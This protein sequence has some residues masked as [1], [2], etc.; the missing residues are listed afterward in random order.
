LSTE[1][2]E[3]W[4]RER[5]DSPE[6]LW[7]IKRL[8]ANDTLASGSHQAGPYLPKSVAFR[9]F[10]SISKPELQNPDAYLT[11]IIDSHG[12][13]GIDVRITWYNAK[14]RDECHI[15]RWG[16]K[17]SP[18][19]DPDATGS[20]AVFAF[21]KVACRDADACRVWICNFEEEEFLQDCL[22]IIDPG[23]PLFLESGLRPAPAR[24]AA[25]PTSCRLT[26]ETMPVSW[27]GQFPAGAEIV[28]HSV[29]LRPL[30]GETAD[31]RLIGRRECEYEMFRSIEEILVLPRIS[32][33][34]SSVDEFIDYSNAVNNRRKSRSGRSLELH[35]ARIFTEEGV[36]HSH[37][38]V[39]EGSKRPD[40]LF[41]SGSHYRDGSGPVWMLAAKTT[42][43]D[44][45]RQIL[46]EADRIPVKHLATLQEGVSSNQYAEM[47]SA[48]VR[49]V[50]PKPL[51][52]RFPKEVRPELLTVEQFISKVRL[53]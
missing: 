15:T 43:K 47:K 4:L 21:Q 39:S 16:G 53:G 27:Q 24:E 5:G 12:L 6:W 2:F 52:T 30:R 23:K 51:H 7:F 38:E 33:G 36:P 22:D 29:L 17:N 50:V 46:N 8:A 37:G 26:F 13:P 25:R 3:A 14:S 28:E 19:L 42:C 10:P 41:P 34:F 48:G 32:C 35:L 20:I 45:W 31:R 40:F 18:L 9:L 11:A 44:R 1:P 49:L